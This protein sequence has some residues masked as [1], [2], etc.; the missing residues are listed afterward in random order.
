MRVHLEKGWI[1]IENAFAYV[2]QRMRIAHRAGD[3]VSIDAI[4]IGRKNQFALEL[5]HF[6][7]CVAENRQP[8]TP[9]EEGVQD[10]LIME[11]IYESART[12]RPVT[13]PEVKGR[14]TTR[15]PAPA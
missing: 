4:E 10:H 13:L 15:G 8:H 12:G 2:G 1:D 5:D 14:D 11:A 6:A 9:G 3:N 7:T